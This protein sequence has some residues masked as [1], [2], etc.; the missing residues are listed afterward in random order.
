MFFENFQRKP[1]SFGRGKL[2]HF[3]MIF[4]LSLEESVMHC[5]IYKTVAYTW[6]PQTRERLDLKEQ[7]SQKSEVAT[8]K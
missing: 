6:R 5:S 7:C 2:T 3:L 4:V 1:T 8:Q